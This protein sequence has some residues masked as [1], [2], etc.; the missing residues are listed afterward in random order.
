MDNNIGDSIQE[1]DRTYRII[2]GKKI[3]QIRE[4]TPEKVE[5]NRIINLY[6]E[7]NLSI[8]EYLKQ[9]SIKPNND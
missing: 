3:Y 2:N 4:D 1:G 8:I 9:K 7:S 5:L 6:R